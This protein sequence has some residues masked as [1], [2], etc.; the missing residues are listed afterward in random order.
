MKKIIALLSI[1]MFILSS[2]ENAME[3]V[4]PKDDNN[5]NAAVVITMS[6]LEKNLK[7]ASVADNQIQA[8]DT[9]DIND[10]R[11]LNIIFTAYKQSGELADGYFSVS[12]IDS[13]LEIE[14][15]YLKKALNNIIDGPIANLKPSE[16][17]LYRINFH[18]PV[19]N[20]QMSF[21]IRH[22]GLPGQIGDDVNNLF[23]FRMSK[24]E[25]H[26]FNGETKIAYHLFLKADDGEIDEILRMSG[27]SEIKA[28]LFHLNGETEFVAKKCNYSD[29]ISFS[30]L[31]D[32]Y[33]PKIENN[34]NVFSFIFFVG[35]YGEAWYSFS[36]SYKSN[37]TKGSIP[38]SMLSF[39]DYN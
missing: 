29:Y 24:K 37:W 26:S 11:H 5:T 34:Q 38:S 22:S 27:E 7:S 10:A 15:H 25:H 1:I 17:G 19:Y 35:Q 2:C 8:G 14:N 32:D 12:L 21:Y 20:N 31:K 33:R 4:L 30:F 39:C 3:D 9:I 16:L 6:G 28:R 23:A 18:Q 13:D 36:S